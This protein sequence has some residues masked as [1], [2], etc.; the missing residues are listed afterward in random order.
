MYKFKGYEGIAGVVVAWMSNINILIIWIRLH[1]YKSYSY[2]FFFDW[3]FWFVIVGVTLL[4]PC[5]TVIAGGEIGDV[6]ATDF[7]NYC[8]E[9]ALAACSTS[10]AYWHSLAMKL[11]NY[12]KWGLPY[13]E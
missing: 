6:L 3:R 7:E 1:R 12:L 11:V 8:K 5:E 9:K 4:T 10:F 2:Q 13:Q